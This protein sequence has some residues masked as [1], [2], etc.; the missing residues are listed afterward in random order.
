[1]LNLAELLNCII[2]QFK[3]VKI[4]VRSVPRVHGHKR[5]RPPSTRRTSWKLVGNP[6]W[7]LVRKKL[8]SSWQLV[9]W[10]GN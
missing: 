8:E 4:Y 1:M 5:L 6:G 3:I 2:V 10:V 9:G 7:Q